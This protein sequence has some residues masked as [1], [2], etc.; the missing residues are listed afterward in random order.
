MEQFV[1]QHWAEIIIIAVQCGILKIGYTVLQ[2]YLQRT[3]AR[4]D[5]IRSLLRTEIISICYKSLEQ[6][7]IAIYNLENLIDMY[8]SY[9]ALGGNGAIT[10]IYEQTTRLPHSAPEKAHV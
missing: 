7:Y 6:G 2:K 8:K 10:Q 5:A 3:E 1:A 9:K 4:D